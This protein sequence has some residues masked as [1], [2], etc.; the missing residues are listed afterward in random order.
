MIRFLVSVAVWLASSAIGL[1]AAHVLLDGV[2]V[3]ALSFVLVAA[4]FAA[5]QAVLA[6]FVAT[7]ARRYAP[8][9]LGGVGLLTTFVALLGTS[10]LSDGL[11]IV[12]V[13]SWV[14]ASLLVWVVTMLATLLLPLLLAGRAVARRRT[15]AAQRSA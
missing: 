10:L 5:V 4:L 7:V 15:A 14:Y 9:L 13:G 2:S 8:A 12:G 11:R 6:P 1:L 3:D